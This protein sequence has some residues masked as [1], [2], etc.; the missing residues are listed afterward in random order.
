MVQLEIYR[1]TFNIF[2][3]LKRNK[4]ILN[5]V[6]ELGSIYSFAWAQKWLQWLTSVQV[7]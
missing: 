1:H 3:F 4:G 5:K 2:G 7:I 6:K